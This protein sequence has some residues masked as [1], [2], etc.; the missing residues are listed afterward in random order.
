MKMR[1]KAS[2]LMVLAALILAPHPLFATDDPGP[3][4]YLRLIETAPLPLLD[5]ADRIEA[6]L[7]S[8]GWVVAA[9]LDCGVDPE[10][11]AFGSRVIVAHHSTYTDRIL[12]YGPHA[13][14]AA[15]VRFAVYEDEGGVHVAATNPLNL[16]RTII[17]E[18]SAPEDWLWAEG[19]I[20]DVA[21]VAFPDHVA[22]AHFGQRREKA[23]IGRTFGIMAGGKFTD[24]IK[25]VST[26][27][28]EGVSTRMIAELLESQIE[29][30]DGDWDWGLRPVYVMDLPTHSVTVL[31]LSA[32]S[33]E[34][35][36]FQIVGSGGDDARRDMAC[37]GLDHAAAFP[38]EVVVTEVDGTI[39][40]SIV[41]EMYRM[42]MYFEDAGKMAFAKNM[43]MPGSIEDEIKDKIR[44]ILN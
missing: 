44:A 19:M 22:P 15:P 16:N 6:S 25:T 13:A 12:A 38:I 24:K 36:A 4:V 28:A 11:C 17:D 1:Q 33:V 20:L 41:E 14:F 18:E 37:P 43:R 3:G 30:L 9:T 34:A 31:G 2:L 5:V 21:R 23:R 8:L 27:P 29:S 26:L 7:T 10:A 35:K 32:G 42:K 39:E 40:V